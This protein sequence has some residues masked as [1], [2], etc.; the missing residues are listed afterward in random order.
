SLPQLVVRDELKRWLHL[1]SN[2][3]SFDSLSQPMVAMMQSGALGRIWS[4]QLPVGAT[5]MARDV[6]QMCDCVPGLPQLLGGLWKVAVKRNEDRVLEQLA[7]RTFRVTVKMFMDSHTLHEA[8]IRQ[9]CVHTGTF[10]DDPRRF[11]FCWRWIFGDA[12]DFSQDKV[13]SSFVPISALK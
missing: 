4:E 6:A 1:V 5:N 7:Q 9:C 8:R 11:S 13:Q 12:S 10:E 3:I 2:T